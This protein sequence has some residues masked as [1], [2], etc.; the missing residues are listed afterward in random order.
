[1]RRL[2]LVSTAFFVSH[3]AHATQ[4]IDPVVVTASRIA[5]PLSTVGSS[6]TVL[7]GAALERQG[8]TQ[9]I[10]ALK[11]VPG[12]SFSRSGGAG[13]VTTARI[14]GAES[15]Q[16]IVMIDG[17]VVN[18]PTNTSGFFDFNDLH[19]HNVER[20]EI[21][22]GP[23]S[24]I[25]GGNAV[26]GVIQIF[27]RRGEGPARVS[28]HAGGGSHNTTSE[29]I[30][31]R[32]KAGKVGYSLQTSN[33]Q[34]TGFPASVAGPEKDGAHLKQLGASLDIDAASRVKLLLSGGVSRLNADFDPSS[35][36]DG[37]AEQVKDSA[38][39]QAEG[40]ITSRGGTLEHVLTAG[41]SVVSR[42]FDEPVGF[43]RHSTFD[44]ARTTL[45]YQ[46]NQRLFVRDTASAG[47]EW[48][49]ETA[50]NTLTSGGSTSTD[51]DRR[52]T[53]RSAYG[54]YIAH[55]T[56]ALT[57]TASAR[58]DT[59]SSF[60]NHTTARLAAAYVLPQIGATVR[61]SAGTAAKNP[62]LYQLYGPYGTATLKPETSKGVDAGIE[63]T[64]LNGRVT[65]E[66]TGFAQVYRNLID[67]NNTT[68]VYDNIV[69]S[70]SRGVETS[71][72][73]AATPSIGLRATHTY[74]LAR[75]SHTHNVLPRRP[76]HTGYVATD[77]RIND[78]ASV[79][80]GVLLVTKQL[81][82]NFSSANTKGYTTLDLHGN[83]QILPQAQ[84][85]LRANNVLDRD[86]QE[87]RNYRSAGRE[88]FGG[89][90]A[91]Y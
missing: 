36:T 17:V 44:G 69:R 78:R 25:Y 82:S 60:D 76:R 56:Q 9:V 81:D 40:R 19:L 27:T 18:D 54:Q 31:V 30:G 1:M 65:T 72:R 67:F 90:R 77:A 70:N 11:T 46:A 74:T 79:G 6:I 21:L 38:Y 49:K 45:R 39:G 58:H 32:G 71:V 66:H 89:V 20:I 52:T 3:T 75:N 4:M 62:S 41:G 59:S 55:P 8:V 12:L 10:D 85:Y 2:L 28:V 7:D 86:F 34:T 88:I 87:V 14:R 13:A 84:L 68:F 47:V 64:W 35:T 26:G 23:Q 48:Q 57:L 16:V 24:A 53:A 83:Y 22:R 42:T 50:D 61:A 5:Q 43:Y 91:E 37:P 33:Y 51:V 80:A 15:S 63:K 29:N 73:V